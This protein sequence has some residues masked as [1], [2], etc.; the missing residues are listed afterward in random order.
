MAYTTLQN[1][2]VIIDLIQQGNSRG[3]SIEGFDAIHETCNAG[4]IELLSYPVK[5]GLS[6]EYSYQIKSINTGMVRPQLGGIVGTARTVVGFYTETAT[7]TTNDILKFYSDANARISLVNIRLTTVTFDLKSTN[8]IAWSEENNKWSD[9]R[10]YNPDCGYSLFANLFTYKNG[11]LYAHQ[12]SN[13]PN[14]F[15][16]VQYK[17]IINFV[18]NADNN[19][20]KTFLS[21]SYESNRLM[22]TTE[23]GI[24]TSL[25][26]VSELIDEDFLKDILDDGVTQVKI[27]D[28]EGIYS[29]GFMKAKPDIIN[30]DVLKGTTATIELIQADDGFMRLENVWIHSEPSKIGSR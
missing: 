24:T 21:I 18:A 12:A 26:K 9:Y 6:Y 19:I 13:T 27:Y 5:A 11:T 20:P 8:T 17:S 7:A 15:Y 4:F 1:T 23:D 3:W 29:A 22:I 25:G 14:N 2:P 28:V 10:S 16:G 30:G